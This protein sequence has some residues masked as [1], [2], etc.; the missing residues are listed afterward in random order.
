MLCTFVSYLGICRKNSWYCHLHG[1][2]RTQAAAAFMCMW[3]YPRGQT[4]LILCPPTKHE[5]C[6]CLQVRTQ[7]LATVTKILHFSDPAVLGEELTD[8]PISSFIASL[9][10][11]K[12]SATA[13]KALQLAEILVH[14]LPAFSKHF[15]KEGVVHAIEQLAGTAPQ[16]AGEEKARSK[17]AKRASQRLKV[18]N[19]SCHVLLSWCSH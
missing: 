3:S 4:Q 19:W 17:A 8:L 1:R 15:L 14:K 10:T 16:L 7:C 6:P 18:C 12:D 9:L 2:S 5:H 11:H 13:A